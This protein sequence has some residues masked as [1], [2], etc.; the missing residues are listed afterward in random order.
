MQT[1]VFH[2]FHNSNSIA[3]LKQILPIQNGGILTMPRATVKAY[4][5]RRLQ[6]GEELREQKIPLIDSVKG[7][8]DALIQDPSMKVSLIAALDEIPYG[9]VLHGKTPD[10]ILY[11]MTSICQTPPKFENAEIAGLPFYSLFQDLLATR[12][13]Q[14]FFANT[15]TN[16]HLKQIFNDY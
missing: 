11:A 8:E 13:G 6:E 4:A 5:S 10:D 9:G 7:L 12:F 2:D 3:G 1:A 16:Y 14:L 15:V